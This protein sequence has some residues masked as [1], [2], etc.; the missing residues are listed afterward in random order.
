MRHHGGQVG[1]YIL[2]LDRMSKN[3]GQV[4][5]ERWLDVRLSRGLVAPE[6]ICP[7]TERAFVVVQVRNR[8]REGHGRSG[9]RRMGLKCGHIHLPWR[10]RTPKC[11]V[12]LIDQPRIRDDP[13]AIEGS[14]AISGW[15]NHLI[16]VIDN[17]SETFFVTRQTSR[18]FFADMLVARLVVAEVWVK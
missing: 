3:F 7:A 9:R 8:A 17:R 14:E 10:V 2:G 16:L 12:R 4:R 18:N 5:Q 6:W 13:L 1:H 11:G 15:F